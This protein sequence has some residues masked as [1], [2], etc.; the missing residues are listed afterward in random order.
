V[1]TCDFSGT[2][3]RVRFFKNLHGVRDIIRSFFKSLRVPFAA[4][5]RKEI[6]PV[7]VNCARDLFQWIG[8]RMYYRFTEWDDVFGV[9]RLGAKLDESFSLRR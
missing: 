7:Y 2:K 8:N 4:R 1:L 6:T 3:A 9:E 5:R